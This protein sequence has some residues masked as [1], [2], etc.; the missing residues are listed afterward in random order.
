MNDLCEMPATVLREKIAR[1]EVSP[2]EVTKA[3][4]DRAFRLQPVLNCLSLIHI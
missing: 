1:R 3:V 2:V 4:L